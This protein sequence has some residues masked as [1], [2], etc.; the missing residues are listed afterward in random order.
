MGIKLVKAKDN[1]AHFSRGE[2]YK[3]TPYKTMYGETEYTIYTENGWFIKSFV[4]EGELL[5]F[6]DIVNNYNFGW[7]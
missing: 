6:F 7:E 2:L 5:Y 3:V 1:S 4:T